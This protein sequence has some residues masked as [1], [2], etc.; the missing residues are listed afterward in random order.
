MSYFV[1]ISEQGPAWVDSHPMREQALWREH[2]DFINPLCERGFVILG[3]PFGSGHP[4]RALL[5][6]TSE[7]RSAVHDQLQEDPWVKAGILR[8]ASIEP[9]KILVSHDKLDPVL[10]EI[11]GVAPLG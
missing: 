3:G 10:A 7:S 5:I 9:W 11:T 2:A 4:H 8:T 6:V 1:V